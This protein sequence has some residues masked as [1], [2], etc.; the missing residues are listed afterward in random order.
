[1][2]DQSDSEA[3]SGSATDG[4]PPQADGGVEAAST[5]ES[6]DVDH[7][8]ET[9][10]STGME[11][12]DE[13]DPEKSV[14]LSGHDLTSPRAKGL[15]L[16]FRQEEKA[17]L[18]EDEYELEAR[19][20]LNRPFAY[21][22]ILQNTQTHTREYRVIEP[23]LDEH[24]AELY[25]LLKKQLTERLL[26]Q[27]PAGSDVDRAAK[28]EEQSRDIISGLAGFT[29]ADP[30][31]E[32][33]L[34]YLRRDLLASY[35]G[36]IDALMRDPNIEEISADGPGISVYVYHREYENL[37]TNIVYTEDELEQFVHQIA[38]RAGN[39]ISTAHPT[40]GMSL[41]DGS[42]V[43]LSLDDISPNGANLTIRKHAESPFTPV[44][45]IEL[46]TFTLEQMAYLWVLI[47]NGSS[48]LITGGTGTG[49]TASLNALTMFIPP[50]QKVVSLEDTQELQIPQDNHV[51]LLTREGYAHEAE[52]EIGM[53]DLLENA[54][55]LR[56]EYLIVGEVR[57]EEARDMFQAMNTGHTTFSTV[58]AD[59]LESAFGRLLNEPMA[60]ERPLVS[61]LDFL[62][63]QTKL[64]AK[65]SENGARRTRRN[66]SIYEIKG[67]DPDSGDINHRRVYQWDEASDDIKEVADSYQFQKLRE[68]GR[69]P[70]TAFNRRRRLLTHLVD[71]GITGYQPVST[72]I[73][74][75]MQAPELVLEQVEE[76]ELNYNELEAL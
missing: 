45:L 43:Q 14:P 35:Y 54:L 25:Q 5:A 1:M 38:Q 39:D 72:A 74:G 59:S 32:K 51:P 19:Y 18:N 56:P 52:A 70:D 49:K 15:V 36:R 58:H 9:H 22:V 47:E 10:S 76:G 67:L 27:V 66:Q 34:Y 12:V 48:G 23:D 71:N 63:V 40:E 13:V 28:L 16:P 37:G 41:P 2:P 26:Y 31:F 8:P 44:E 4:S 42:R 75:F 33:V 6:P 65:G 30:S 60:V 46:G 29:V 53:Y 7:E 64:N 20:W 62:A 61:E 73:R 11:L 24:E 68:Q 57:G 3:S 50:G 55:R 69:D 17:I 21:A